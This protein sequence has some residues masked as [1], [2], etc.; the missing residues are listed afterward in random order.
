VLACRI[1]AFGVE[2][3][4]VLLYREA[5]FLGDFDLTTLN[6]SVEKLFNTTAINTD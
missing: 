3:K 2:I 4:G 5:A 6:F 1:V